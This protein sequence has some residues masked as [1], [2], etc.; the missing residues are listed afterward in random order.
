MATGITWIETDRLTLRQVV[1][2]D[3]DRFVRLFA[4][5]MVTRYLPEMGKSPEKTIRSEI[6]FMISHWAKHGFGNFSVFA[7]DSGMF[8]GYCGVQELH[9]QPGGLAPEDLPEPN[10]VELLYGFARPFW[11]LGMAS[12]V[13]A[14]VL[15]FGFESVHL[16]RVVAAIHP[17]NTPSQNVLRKMGMAPDPSLNYY[18]DCP[19]FVLKA[20]D[21]RPRGG[22]YRMSRAE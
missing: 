6:K 17:D 4:D 10:E 11:G 19:H 21:F 8:A 7:R 5:P 22:L 20:D 15:R 2:E 18:R 12:E 16:D 14:A 3:F 13:A 9:A 1:A